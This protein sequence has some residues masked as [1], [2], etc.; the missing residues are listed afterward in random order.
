MEK[1]QY[2]ELLLRI[3]RIESVVDEILK[4]IPR[5]YPNERTCHE[6]V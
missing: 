4:R 6:E 2:E 1:N 5:P 3:G